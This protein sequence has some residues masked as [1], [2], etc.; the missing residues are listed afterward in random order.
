MAN[1]DLDLSL[2]PRQREAFDS[3]STCQ[4]F[5]GQSE[6]G[7]SH[8]IRVRLIMYCLAVPGLA[9]VLVRK[10]YSDIILNHVEG[11]T[12]FR[13][14]LAPLSERGLCTITKDE[15]RFYND[16]VITFQHCQDERQFDSAQGIEKHMLV[17]DEATQISER[18][19]RFF[20]AWVRMPKEM[21]D[22]IPEPYRSRLPCMIFTANPIG[23][24]VGYFRR[25]FVKARKAFECQEVDGFI[26]QFVPSTSRDNKSVDHAAHDARMAGLGD[27]ALVAALE[28]DWNAPTGDFYPEW[29]EEVHVVP[30]ITPPS[31][32]FRFGGF[33]WG[34]SDPFCVY[35]C[36]VSDGVPFADRLGRKHWFPRG[37]Y[38]VY[39][40][41]YGAEAEDQSKGI[42]MKNSKIRDGILERCTSQAERDMTYLTDSLP[43]KEM[44]GESI[45]EVFWNKGNGIRLIEADTSRIPGWAKLR[46]RLIGFE[47]ETIHVPML[48]ICESCK[49]ARDYVPM[50]QRHPS[51]GKSNDAQEH[52]EATHVCDVLRYISM[53]YQRIKD[54]QEPDVIAKQ[55]MVDNINA[56]TENIQNDRT[57]DSAV[58]KLQRMHNQGD[59]W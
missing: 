3:I 33:D 28:G 59:G 11:R 22:T 48:V 53:A 56:V 2:W 13:W 43:F 45:A 14:L 29:N 30:D 15:I 19:I 4:L 25:Y 6:G 41:W 26:R 23:P 9:A 27:K 50:L 1:I 40:E 36:T 55:S 7:K 42:R 20:S 21:K 10:K 38:V 16:S 47:I 35:W 18:L 39:R 51:E 37:C 5:G 8:Y 49:A 57:F 31:H 58:K 32:W 44:G 52:G 54:I 12:G 24:S 46:D 34:G 17:I